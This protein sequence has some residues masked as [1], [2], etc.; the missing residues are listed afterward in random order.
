MSNL[1]KDEEMIKREKEEREKLAAAQ[2]Q[3]SMMLIAQQQGIVYMKA[4]QSASF[5][6]KRSL[7]ASVLRMLL[8]PGPRE[9]RVEG[10]G[11]WWK[12]TCT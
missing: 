5:A 1:F 11:S 10:I 3:A 6:L 8:C 7:G 2:M 4:S 12:L 9:R